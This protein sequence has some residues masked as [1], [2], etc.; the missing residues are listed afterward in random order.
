MALFYAA[1]RHCPRVPLAWDSGSTEIP[2]D[3]CFS[4]TVRLCGGP[5]YQTTYGRFVPTTGFSS[6]VDGSFY[7]T[8]THLSVVSALGHTALCPASGSA[9]VTLD[10]RR[11]CGVS[12]RT[13]A[14]PIQRL[15]G[16]DALG[17]AG[18]TNI[19]F[20]IFM[21][22]FLGAVVDRRLEGSRK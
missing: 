4:I 16:I 13:A 17:T 12:L 14:A 11:R 3:A 19:R 15:V 9:F 18:I 20:R 8:R 22:D 7:G 10:N 2:A 6:Y 21:A 1:G 5:I